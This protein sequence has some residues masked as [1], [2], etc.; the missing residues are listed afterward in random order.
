MQK[1]IKKNNHIISNAKLKKDEN[2]WLLV[3]DSSE[4]SR[5]VDIDFL[6]F[7]KDYIKLGVAKESL[8]PRII[9][10]FGNTDKT[11]NIITTFSS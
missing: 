5:K 3:E 9:T 8:K 7:P 6:N 4:F 11:I 2:L 10:R 1:T